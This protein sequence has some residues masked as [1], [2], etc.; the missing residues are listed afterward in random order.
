MRSISKKRG[1][2][3][4]RTAVADL[5]FERS[6]GYQVRTTNRAFQTRLRERVERFGVSQGMWYFMRLLW[7]ED[8]LTQRELGR[9]I[10][11]VDPTAFTALSAM[12]RRGLVT[13]AKDPSDGRKIKVFLTAHGKAL[14][15]EMLPLAHEINA[16]GLRGLAR[17]EIATLLRLLKKIEANLTLHSRRKTE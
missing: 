3:T 16:E 12:E 17:E 10:G 6:V 14:R 15:E 5:P 1:G 9:R 7:R 13:R 8:G 4:T 11:L 2:G